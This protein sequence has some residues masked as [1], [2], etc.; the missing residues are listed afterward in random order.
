MLQMFFFFSSN[1]Q[2][3]QVGYT[4]TALPNILEFIKTVMSGWFSTFKIAWEVTR[5]FMLQKV[6]MQVSWPLLIIFI[7]MYLVLSCCVK[8]KLKKGTDEW[9]GKKRLTTWLASLI[10]FNYCW[11]EE[12]LDLFNEHFKCNHMSLKA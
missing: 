11:E 3:S 5:L 12:K 10:V 6:S 7:I 1:V 9:G 2:L 8:W 4:A